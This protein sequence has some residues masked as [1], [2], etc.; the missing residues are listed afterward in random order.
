MKSLVITM[1]GFYE[2]ILRLRKGYDKEIIE[3][4]IPTF[5]VFKLCASGAFI[6]LFLNHVNHIT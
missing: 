5:C 4:L 6:G 3:K 1:K 2:Q